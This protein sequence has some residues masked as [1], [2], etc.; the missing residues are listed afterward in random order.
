M[1]VVGGIDI[2]WFTLGMLFNLKVIR[3]LVRDVRYSVDEPITRKNINMFYRRAIFFIGRASQNL[4]VNLFLLFLYIVSIKMILHLTFLSSEFFP[5]L[6]YH[7]LF[8]PIF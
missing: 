7:Y 8:F 6:F 4:K 5:S 1:A 2:I 3:Q